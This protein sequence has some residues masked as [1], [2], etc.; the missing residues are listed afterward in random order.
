MKKTR[1]IAVTVLA[2]VFALGTAAAAADTAGTSSGVFT[3]PSYDGPTGSSYDSGIGTN[4]YAWGDPQPDQSWLQFNGQAFSADYEQD[5]V[6]GNLSYYNG[7][8]AHNTGANAIDLTVYMAFTTPTG[9]NEDFT[10]TLGLVNVP[11]NNNPPDDYV[12]LPTSFSPTYFNVDGTD[13]TLELLGFYE[14]SEGGFTQIDKFFVAESA[15][16]NANLHARLTAEFPP[17][18]D[19][20][21]EASSVALAS[22]GLGMLGFALRRRK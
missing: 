19:P 15:C 11:N 1:A 9:V 3:N 4:T 14:P 17:A 18:P 13:Y 20:V 12:Y 8:I 7:T 10:Y 16:A 6:V 2:L 22:G 5:F 21:P